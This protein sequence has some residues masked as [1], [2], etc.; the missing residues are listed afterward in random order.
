VRQQDAYPANAGGGQLQL[1]TTTAPPPLIKGNIS[2][3]DCMP[4]ASLYS[5]ELSY[6]QQIARKLRIEY[7]EDIYRH[8]YYTVTL[9][10][11]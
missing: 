6:R 1:C 8:K 7:A 2:V 3:A 4:L 10:S 5:Q 9:K 11:R